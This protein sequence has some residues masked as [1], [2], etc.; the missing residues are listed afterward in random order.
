MSIQQEAY[1][2]RKF[3][4]DVVPAI[5]AEQT[6]SIVPTHFCDL[7]AAIWPTA[8]PNEIADKASLVQLQELVDS[9]ELTPEHKQM[10]NDYLQSLPGYG[11]E[12]AKHRHG[13]IL[14]FLLRNLR[15]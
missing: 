11:T 6:D 9:G 3:G 8:S 1:E 5:D 15:E 2:G 14:A 4:G 10:L 12:E 13:F 7:V